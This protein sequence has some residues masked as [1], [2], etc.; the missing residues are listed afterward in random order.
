MGWMQ[1]LYDTYENC[2]S[3]VGVVE[4]ENKTPLM[5]IYHMTQQAQIEAIIDTDGCWRTARVVEDKQ[6]RTTLIPCTEKSAAR[7]NKPVPHP[8]FDNLTYLAGDYIEFRKLKEERY[9]E[10]IAQLSEWC[11][12]PNAHP[13]VK[14]VLKY[15]KKGCLMHDLIASGVLYVDESGNMPE[16]WKGGDDAPPIFKAVAG[17]QASAFVRFQVVPADGSEDLHS[18]IWENPSV[19][20]SYIDYQNSLP[21]ETDFC[22]VL[23]KKMPVSELSPKY[24]RRP[25][26]GAKL[27]SANDGSGFTYRGRF[28][29]QSQAY[30]IGRE[31]NEKAHNALKWLIPRQAYFNGEQVILSWR[32]DGAKTPN[33]CCNS[34]DVLF[35]LEPDKP[36]VST[37][38]DFANKFRNAISGYGGRLK[39]SEESCIIGLD[40]ATPGRLSVF[41][42]RE[43]PEKDLVNRIQ[44]WHETCRWRFQE[45][46]KRAKFFE[47]NAKPIPFIGAPSPETIAEAA[48][49]KQINDKLKKSTVQRLLPCIVDRAALPRDIM[50]CAVR[51]ASNPEGLDE[52]DHG[53]TLA[54]ACALIRKYHNDRQNLGIMK[55][56]EYKER[57]KMALDPKETDRNYLFG[58]A[59]AYAQQLENYAL[60]LQGEKRSTNAERMQMAFSQHPAR[61]WKTLYESLSPYL[62]RLGKRGTRYC[63]ELNEV[64]SKIGK[65]DFTNEPLNELYLLGYAC[66]MQKFH[67]EHEANREK[68]VIMDNEGEEK[69]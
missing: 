63:E 15:L 2:Q 17:D 68:T 42:Y 21:V 41:Y 43:M 13:K 38:E 64:I 19:W 51:R 46:P 37:G 55:T 6:K 16:K 58:R 29:T 69:E 50:L 48:Y 24:I 44:F 14:A 39:D 28:A 23:G 65:E 12:S 32:T 35:D 22:Y 25:G 53:R 56:N 8:L 34:L 54:V 1:K 60:N 9:P 45:F 52:S 3:L 27:I 10:Y 18:R 26:D 11:S 49:G 4:E 31:T 59:L 33:P 62:Q 47:K 20:Q 67:E 7:T 40:S 36:V 61:M 30:S 5:P 66:Q 57:W